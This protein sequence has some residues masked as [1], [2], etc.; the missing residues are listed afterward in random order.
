MESAADTARISATARISMTDELPGAVGDAG[1]GVVIAAAA[2]GE[3]PGPPP[4]VLGLDDISSINN[5]VLRCH[6]FTETVNNIHFTNNCW[7]THD[8]DCFIKSPNYFIFNC[9]LKIHDLGVFTI[10]TNMAIPIGY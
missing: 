1:A 5:D 8:S 9:L 6:A 2:P 10:M 3:L 4:L 7:V